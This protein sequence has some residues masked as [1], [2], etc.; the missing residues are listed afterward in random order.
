MMRKFYFLAFCTL[1]A[2]RDLAWDLLLGS[3]K[4]SIPIPPAYAGLVM[5]LTSTSLGYLTYLLRVRAIE[6]GTN[7]REPLGRLPW[8]RWRQYPRPVKRRFLLL[9][10]A[11]LVVYGATILGIATAGASVF[12]AIDYALVP[13]AT[14]IIGGL[15]DSGSRRGHH[16]V[17]GMVA[18]GAVLL[19]AH[20]S[21]ASGVSPWSVAIGGGLAL[22]SGA[23]TA[24]CTSLQ[25]EQLNCGMHPDEVLLFRFPITAFGMAC[26]LGA[27][28]LGSPGIL[29]LRILGWPTVILFFVSA[30]GGFLPLY[31]LNFGLMRETVGRFAKYLIL[32]PL[33]V[34]VG[35]PFFLSLM[36]R[37]WKSL[38]ML[39]G[40]G[41]LLLVVS[42]LGSE[43]L[44]EREVRASR[45]E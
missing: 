33:L 1:L 31:L 35:N 43:V 7:S 3:D 5:G 15:F 22:I 8:H 26:W 9:G 14:V 27:I 11:T 38:N 42:F 41:C 12:D 13:L 19:L 10:T 30:A 16:L 24:Y 40:L 6:R 20:P 37:N 2:L 29:S 18:L 23:F 44:D 25:K 4:V 36:G 21:A 39:E 28:Y 34:Y 17:A 32:I 45:E